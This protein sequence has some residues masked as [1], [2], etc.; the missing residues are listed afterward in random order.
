MEPGSAAHQGEETL[1]QVSKDIF[2][3][4]RIFHGSQP[5]LLGPEGLPKAERNLFQDGSEVCSLYSIYSMM[6][7]KSGAVLHRC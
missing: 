4:P 6:S 7:D 5:G 3:S 1:P 2:M